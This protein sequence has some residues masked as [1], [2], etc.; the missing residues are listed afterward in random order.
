MNPLFFANVLAG[1]DAALK[2]AD[3]LDATLKAAKENAEMTK[4]QEL[5]Y[6]MHVAERMNSPHWKGRN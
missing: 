6:D 5:A 4:E 1:I 2:L 3:T